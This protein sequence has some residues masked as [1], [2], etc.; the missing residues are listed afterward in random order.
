MMETGEKPCDVSTLPYF[1]RSAFEGQ[2][3]ANTFLI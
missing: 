2:N 1:S 3:T